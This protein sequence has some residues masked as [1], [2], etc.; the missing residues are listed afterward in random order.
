MQFTLP[1]L[2]DAYRWLCQQR[3]HFPPITDLWKAKPLQKTFLYWRYTIHV[4]HIIQ[5]YEQLRMKKATQIEMASVLGQYVNRWQR[6]VAAG[7]ADIMINLTWLCYD[8]QNDLSICTFEPV[9]TI[10]HN[11]TPKNTKP[12][13]RTN[14]RGKNISIIKPTTNTPPNS[15]TAKRIRVDHSPGPLPPRPGGRSPGRG[16]WLCL[17]LRHMDY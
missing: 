3:K 7:L 17:V 8:E 4:L 14:H 6:W 15:T 13:L 5:L 1:Q 12:A 16:C 2:D 9:T 10:F 11:Q